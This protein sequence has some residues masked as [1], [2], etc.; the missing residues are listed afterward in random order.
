M[1]DIKTDNPVDDPPFVPEGPGPKDKTDVVEYATHR[2]LLG[3]KKILQ[4]KYSTNLARLAELEESEKAREES[5]LRDQNKYKELLEQKEKELEESKNR[6]SLVE[7]DRSDSYKLSSFLTNMGGSKIDSQYFSLI[8]LDD[9]CIDE[10]GEVD[11]QS[12]IEAVNKFKVSHPRLVVDPKK[13]LPAN[14]IG[15]KSGGL[16]YQEWRNLGSDKEMRERYKELTIV[17]GVPQ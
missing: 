11:Q 3:E 4:E 14:K 7:K 17:D 9:I 12:V 2:K 16:S 8:P 13:D 10:T 1:T 15:S 6:L 5:S